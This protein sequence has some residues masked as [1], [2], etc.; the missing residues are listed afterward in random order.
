MVSGRMRELLDWWNQQSIEWSPV[1]T[2]GILHYQFE[3]IHPFADGNCR[4]G[5]MLAL[6]ELYRR[7]FDTHHV[8]SVD[9]FYWE[10]RP[11]YYA[12]L[13]AV[14]PRGGDLTAWLEYSTEGLRV[15]LDRVWLRVQ[16]FAA[17]SG[18]KKTVLRP[19]Q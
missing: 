19:K 4:A 9:E 18:S 11:R 5:R 15:T 6:W 12:S 1:I 17:R 3:E 2:S 10:D 13:A 8:F 16:Q 7:G 14:P